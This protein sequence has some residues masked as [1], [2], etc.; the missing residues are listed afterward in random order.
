GAEMREVAELSGAAELHIQAILEALGSIPAAGKKLRVVLDA[1]N[2]AGSLVGPKLLEALGVE[3][4]PINET[5]NGSFPRP[6][7]PLAENLGDL[8]AKVRAHQAD[9][10]FAQDMDADRLAIVS[11]QGVPIGEEYTLV[12]AAS[13]VLGRTPGPVVAN[14]STTSLL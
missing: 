9:I 12:L 4:I 5:P 2:G 6:A 8:C 11:E 10:G 14:L 1:C 13:Y 3:V 7:E